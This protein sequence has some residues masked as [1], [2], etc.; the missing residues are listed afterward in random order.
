MTSR[1]LLTELL[2]RPRRES[3]ALRV[4][5]W[6]VRARAELTVAIFLVAGFLALRVPAGLSVH[7]AL[8]IETSVI[9]L[10]VVLPATRVRM[11]AVTSRHRVLRCFIETRTMTPDGSMPYLLWSSPAPVGERIRAWLPA[12]LS[13]NDI[14]QITE[15]LAAACY[16]AEAR[17]EVNR[18]FTHLVTILIVRRDPF[19]GKRL[20][21]A[22]AKQVTRTHGPDKAFM[23]LPDRDTLPVPTPPAEHPTV[24]GAMARKNRRTPTG[25]DTS[26]HTEPSTPPPVMGVGGMDVSDYV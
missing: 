8:I 9:I 24:I 1:G 10:V 7:T 17:V 6:L 11:W 5:G 22:Y 19:T 2:G 3:R 18:R 16:A 21:P 20:T 14:T 4:L 13:V 25:R 12:G 15:A 23:P 26:T